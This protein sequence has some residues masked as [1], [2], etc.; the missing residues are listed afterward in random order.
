MLFVGLGVIL[1][2]LKLA[3]VDPVAGLAWYW[4]LSPFVGAV[5]WWGWADASGFT[6]RREMDRMDERKAARRAKQMEALGQTD[7]DK[8]RR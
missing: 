6:K 8:K 3:G 5:A 7:H 1:L 4:V 2:V